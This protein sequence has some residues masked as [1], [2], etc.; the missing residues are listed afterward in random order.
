MPWGRGHG[1]TLTRVESSDSA[2][3]SSLVLASH[4]WVAGNAQ[5]YTNVRPINR[6]SEAHFEAD[7]QQV[8]SA[9][10]QPQPA[11]DS[12]QFQVR[13]LKGPAQQH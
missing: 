6:A 3:A 12:Q 8:G 5:A 13:Q 2:A 10:R 7:M 1:A 4:T 9:M 11:F